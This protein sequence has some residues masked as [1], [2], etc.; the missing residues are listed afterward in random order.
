MAASAPVEGRL[1]LVGAVAGSGE[2]VVDGVVD[3][4][5]GR[6]GVRV[7]RCGPAWVLLGGEL[8]EVLG[9][10]VAVVG[11]RNRGRHGLHCG[12]PPRIMRQNYG[13]VLPMPIEW[14]GFKVSGR[15]AAVVPY[16]AR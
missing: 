2:R 4:G 13:A 15:A 11:G 14:A 5:G 12:G 10:R 3:V 1:G 7:F 6:H 9:V 8:L 16:A